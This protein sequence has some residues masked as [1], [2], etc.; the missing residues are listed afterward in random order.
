MFKL[1]SRNNK[2]KE[3]QNDLLLKKTAALLIHA[4]KI[5]E[6]YTDKEKKIIQKTLI[7]L[8][9]ESKNIEKVYNEAENSER[10]ANQILDFTREIKNS[11]EMFKKKVIESLW[12]IIFSDGTSDMYEANFMRRIAGLIYIDSKMMG[13]IKEK[14]KKNI[15]K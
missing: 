3:D 11:E 6:N 13:D 8:G 10:D 12:K 15:I 1:F 2:K 5:D 7:D 14:V 9:V 4:A